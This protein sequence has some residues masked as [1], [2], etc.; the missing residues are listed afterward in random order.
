MSSNHQ[1]VVNCPRCSSEHTFIVWDSVNV[2]VDPHLK[3]SLVNGELTTF[4]CPNCSTETHLEFNCLYHDMDLQ[5]ALFLKY[6]NKEGKTLVE[7]HSSN[8]FS[9]ISESYKCRLVTSY[10]ELL[11]KI[12]IFDDGFIDIEIELLK[13]LISIKVGIDIENPFY[14]S[15][16]ES[17]F[18]KK[19][20]LVFALLTDQ[21]FIKYKYPYKQYYKLIAPIITKINTSIYE[22]IKEW[23]Y[24]NR[25]FMIKILEQ[26]GL[27]REIR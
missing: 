11:D 24:I 21:G 10:H 15:G 14:Y 26:S 16:I 6:P 23:P 13:L 9:K 27:I 25:S 17:T 2:T 8:M 20:K 12:R 3:Q 22:D 1:E 19:K 7:S 18:L 5:I 4:H